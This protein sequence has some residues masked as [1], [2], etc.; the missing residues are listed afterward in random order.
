MSKCERK[1]ENNDHTERETCAHNQIGSSTSDI[2]NYV[3]GASRR[4]KSLLIR[5]V[6]VVSAW[7][8]QEAAFGAAVWS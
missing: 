5:T 1:R 2:T 8:T 7:H 4:A 3:M 6:V